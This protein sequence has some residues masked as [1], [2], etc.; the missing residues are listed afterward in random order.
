MRFYFYNSFNLSGEGF[1]YVVYNTHL[2]RSERI[3]RENKNDYS[4]HIMHRFSHGG[5]ETILE[6]TDDGK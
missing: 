5:F 2:H 6:K 3:T 1:S 4:H